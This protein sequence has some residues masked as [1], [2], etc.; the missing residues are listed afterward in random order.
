MRL[1]LETRHMGQYEEDFEE[2]KRRVRE[3]KYFGPDCG[4]RGQY[5]LLRVL[6]V[7]GMGAVF[8]ARD[9]KLG[10]KVAV[11]IAS[12]N[13]K[14]AERFRVEAM[15]TAAFT[16]CPNIV[17]VY[18]AGAI[19][20]ELYISMELI[21][22]K[23]LAGLLDD[24]R[25]YDD[26]TGPCVQRGPI[27]EDEWR[28][29]FAQIFLDV[30]YALAFAHAGKVTHRDVKPQNIMV[31]D[32]YGRAKLLDF[33]IAKSKRNGNKELTVAGSL[34]GTLY[35]MAPE[36][37]GSKVDVGPPADQW[38]AA[39]VLHESLTG[40][41]PYSEG[42]TG[43]DPLH[44]VFA[45]MTLEIANGYGKYRARLPPWVPEEIGDMLE[46][47]L[48]PQPENRLESMMEA[49]RI[50][51]RANGLRCPTDPSPRS[52]DDVE[53]TGW[54]PIPDVPGVAGHETLA[55]PPDP[56]VPSANANIDGLDGR[57][58]GE[59]SV[60][61]RVSPVP[62]PPPPVALP[63][64]APSSKLGDAASEEELARAQALITGPKI[65]STHI[66]IGV[67]LLV[68]LGLVAIAVWLG[69]G[70]PPRPTRVDAAAAR[71]TALDAP[72]A[73]V[74]LDVSPSDVANAPDATVSDADASSDVDA[75]APA[76]TV[77][78][79]PSTNEGDASLVDDDTPTAQEEDSG[80]RRRRR[81]ENRDTSSQP[82]P[83][84]LSSHERHEYQRQC[85]TPGLLLRSLYPEIGVSTCP[86]PRPEN[87]EGRNARTDWCR[88]CGHN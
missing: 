83:S 4:G 17:V 81:R 86:P 64:Q 5:E 73:S 42:C 74:P 22:G 12:A 62:A 43:E 27:T 85:C 66:A 87:C 11:K 41:I 88:W 31:F 80:S 69:S 8:E 55:A 56:P 18:D 19:S 25:V 54:H 71:T 82:A 28:Q 37:M 14:D 59:A 21:D 68:L 10:R 15:S 9:R 3:L 2:A 79:T 50:V 67:G 57:Q 16:A 24:G 65:R 77:D 40:E 72:E 47:M 63:A 30:F 60:I 46:G 70:S 20:N 38:A 84:Q 32:G 35:Y 26:G 39:A 51:A 34:L 45:K 7:G 76:A 1:S 36:Q 53:A 78:S 52:T 44:V 58:P 61:L 49:V 48:Q 75:A 6:G 23:D 13:N 29:H 33:G